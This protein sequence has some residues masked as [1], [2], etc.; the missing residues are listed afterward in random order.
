[1]RNNKVYVI[2]KFFNEIKHYLVREDNGGNGIFSPDVKDAKK[3]LDLT[4]A[5][6]WASGYEDSA[7]E[8]IK[9]GEVL[10]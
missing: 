8:I 9:E 2:S 6:I 7:I 4:M 1:M 5:K 3:F 10:K